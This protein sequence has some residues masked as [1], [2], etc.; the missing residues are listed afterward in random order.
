MKLLAQRVGTGNRLL[1]ALGTSGLIIGVLS[2]LSFGFSLVVLFDE[3]HHPTETSRTAYHE[4][5]KGWVRSND[6]LG[7]TLVGRGE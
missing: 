6:Y 5:F 2:L 3:Y 7:Y 1:S 4:F